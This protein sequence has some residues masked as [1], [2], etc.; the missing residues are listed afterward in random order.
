VSAHELW[1]NE[2]PIANRACVTLAVADVFW[3]SGQ[4]K[5]ERFST[6]EELFYCFACADYLSTVAEHP[7]WLCQQLCCPNRAQGG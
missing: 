5:V 2:S 4:T 7:L 1:P 6:R 3:R